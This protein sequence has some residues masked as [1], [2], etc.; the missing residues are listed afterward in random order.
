M[1]VRKSVLIAG[2]VLAAG[3]P[4]CRMG[5]PIHVWEPPL[6]ASTVGKRVAVSAIAGPPELAT[7]IRDRLVRG[8]PRD[9]G[10]AT[11]LVDAQALQSDSPI[12]LVSAND[13]EMSDV[14]LAPVA[15]RNGF[16]MMLHGQLIDS[17]SNLAE[18]GFR[19]RPGVRGERLAISW[20]LT[21]LA[22][23]HPPLGMPIVVDCDAVA[24]RYPDVAMIPD[25]RS[26]IAEA[27]A[28]ETYRLLTPTVATE[29]VQLAIPYL[30]PGSRGIR[31]GNVQALAGNWSAAQDIWRETLREHPAQ[32]AALVNLAIAAVAEQDF[33][34]AKR[35]ARLATA[36]HP[37]PLARETLVWVELM[38]RQY[39]QAFDLPDPPEGW[40][41]TRFGGDSSDSSSARDR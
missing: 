32:S 19:E 30:A 7:E 18:Q 34:E 21:D 28:R 27:A 10:R 23:N 41:V 1:R 39:H 11:Q 14:A 4:G 5:V 8:A 15:R 6:L 25:K 16:D 35:L 31:R 40:F 26:A 3:T 13:V 22:G 38:Q 24:D 17:G 9:T 29:R 36:R 12:R 20:R 37:S 2:L 33:S